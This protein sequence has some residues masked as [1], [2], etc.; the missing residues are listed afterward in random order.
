MFLIWTNHAH[1][2]AAAHDLAFVANPSDRC[3]YLHHSSQLAPRFPSSPVA[4]FQ[5]PASRRSA[6]STDPVATVP[7]AR[8]RR[9]VPERSSFQDRLPRARLPAAG[10][11]SPPGT[12]RAAT[13]PSPSLQPSVPARSPSN[14]RRQARCGSST[15][16]GH[17]LSP[18]PCARSALTGCHPGSRLSSH[19]TAP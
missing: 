9:P 12:A 7:A 18:P 10:A 13:A 16:A 4:S 17:P 1:H 11:Q 3:P 6:L 15:R 2:A 5:L 14:P 19:P 8:D